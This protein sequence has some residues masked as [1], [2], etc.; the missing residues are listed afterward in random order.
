[1]HS[2]GRRSLNWPVFNHRRKQNVSSIDH[3]DQEEIMND[4]HFGAF[5]AGPR[6]AR[7]S[8]NLRSVSRTEHLNTELFDGF[9]AGPYT[10]LKPR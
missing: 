3:N 10:A 9:F 8:R 7:R 4:Q 5:A 2:A 1:M 6:T